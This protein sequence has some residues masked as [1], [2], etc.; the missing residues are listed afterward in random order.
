MRIIPVLDIR[1]G[2]AVHAIAGNRAYYE[3]L[4]SILHGDPDPIALARSGR[5]AWGLTDLY[6]AD[7]GSILGESPPDL[8]LYRELRGLGL[9]LWVDAG[10]REPGDLPGLLESGVHRLVVGLETVRGPEALAGI[11]DRAGADRVAFS[12]DLREGRPMVE[13]A[14]DWK[15]EDP[16]EIARRAIEAG[17]RTIIRLDLARVGTGRGLGD[18]SGI[19]GS[20]TVDWLLGGGIAGPDD[21][22]G[23]EK[24]G[25]AGVLIGS[26]LH[27]GRIRAEH[28]DALR[29][30]SSG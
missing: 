22:R 4:R 18:L 11:V 16:S 15:S 25:V 12:L 2:R 20:R 10:I 23:L 7:L 28:L 3:T 9:D 19:A 14:L 13:T 6:L 27:D 5:D 24:V 21:L 29:G 17:V 26:A 30:R 1:H 8:S